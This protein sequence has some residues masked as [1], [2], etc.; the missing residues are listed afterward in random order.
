MMRF[1]VPG[2]NLSGE[3]VQIP[4]DVCH[5]AF[6][7]RRLALGMPFQIYNGTGFKATTVV[8]DWTYGPTIGTI[9]S[10]EYVD[11]ELKKPIRVAQGLPKNADRM[12]QVLQHGTELGVAAF[13][14][15]AGERSVAKLDSKDKIDKRM[16][17]W[18][19]IIASAAEQS[20]R[21][22]LP[23]VQWHHTVRTL[24]VS[25]TEV[26][27]VLHE[28]ASLP[29]CETLRS[30]SACESYMLVIGPEGGLS[31]SEI[32]FCKKGNSTEVSLGPRILRTE[33]AALAAVAQLSYFLES[34]S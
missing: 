16:D 19:M 20:G 5:H 24:P 4:D 17:R 28:G 25:A 13:H 33:T 23:T 22:F 29:L 18:K 15:F 1:L 32:S 6:R 30:T 7:V 26:L 3:T 9:T 27:L 12:E 31:D 11:T 14:V 34:N 2:I 21:G 8:H 10:V